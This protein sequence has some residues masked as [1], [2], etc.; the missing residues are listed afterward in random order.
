MDETF[1]AHEHTDAAVGEAPRRKLKKLVYS[2]LAIQ[3]VVGMAAMV[4][5][6][7][8]HGNASSHAAAQLDWDFDNF[9][10]RRE[11]LTNP[12]APTTALLRDLESRQAALIQQI[13]TRVQDFDASI[14]SLS[15]NT[16]KLEDA[17]EIVGSYASIS[18]QLEQL[19][20]TM[21]LR[22]STK[23]VLELLTQGREQ[24]AI[25]SI[26]SVSQ[27]P[28]AVLSEYSLVQ[29]D[30]INYSAVDGLSTAG[31]LPAIIAVSQAGVAYQ[32]AHLP[33][34]TVLAASILHNLASAAIPDTGSATGDQHNIGRQA[35]SDALAIRTQLGDARAIGIA[36]YMVGV[37]QYKDRKLADAENTLAMAR[38]KLTNTATDEQYAWATLFLGYTQLALGKAEGQHLVD[39]A[40]VSFQK[41]GSSFGLRYVSAG[42][43]RSQ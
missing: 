14:D 39:E 15:D 4:V 2:A 22:P 25:A 31:M 26:E 36:E 33:A 29:L 8:A 34:E 7:E 40:R 38:A 10:V 30:L 6:A 21:V 23:H 11:S 1:S 37:Y 24:E 42:L 20:D 18:E 3:G 28:S 16:S 12:N 13:N 32:E 27:D 17:K 43:S 9:V 5:S 41:V 35:A 19:T